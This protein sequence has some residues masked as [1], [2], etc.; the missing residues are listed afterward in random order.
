MLKFSSDLPIRKMKSRNAERRTISRPTQNQKNGPSEAPRSE[1]RTLPNYYQNAG[2]RVIITVS[3]S[4]YKR[5][6]QIPCKHETLDCI[7]LL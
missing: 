2:S 4:D 6:M 7:N 3:E 5:S 1:S